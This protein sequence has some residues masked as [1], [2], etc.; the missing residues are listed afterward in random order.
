MLTRAHTQGIKLQIVKAEELQQGLVGV[1]LPEDRGRGTAVHD[2]SQMQVLEVSLTD[3]LLEPSAVLERAS[4]VLRGKEEEEEEQEQDEED[5]ET[6]G[7]KVKNRR[8]DAAQK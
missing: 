5:G 4:K 3:A 2:D 8:G 7:S 1:K 6:R